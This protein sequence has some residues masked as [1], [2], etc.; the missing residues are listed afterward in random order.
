MKHPYTAPRTSKIQNTNNT[1]VD[2]D[3]AGTLSLITNRNANGTD[4]L[5]GSL[6]AFYKTNHT[7]TI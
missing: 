3:A 5:E 1:N 7:L 4:T 2:E 6:A